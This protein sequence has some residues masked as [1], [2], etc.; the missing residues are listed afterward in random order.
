MTVKEVMEQY[1]NAFDYAIEDRDIDAEY[2]RE[3][4]GLW[5]D[6]STGDCIT[7]ED[8]A[9]VDVT[10]VDTTTYQEEKTILMII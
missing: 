3:S 5:R 1:G 2:W 6:W 9:D 10:E 7:D 8:Y 4:N